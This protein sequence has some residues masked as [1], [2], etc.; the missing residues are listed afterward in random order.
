MCVC[1]FFSYLC[2]FF[3]LFHMCTHIFCCCCFRVRRKA[4]YGSVDRSAF[5]LLAAQLN[6]G[7]GIV[8]AHGIIETLEQKFKLRYSRVEHLHRAFQRPSELYARVQSVLQMPNTLTIKL[9]TMKIPK[10]WPVNGNRLAKTC[11]FDQINMS[12]GQ[13]KS[14]PTNCM[15]LKLDF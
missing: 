11:N 14:M 6:C 7:D 12:H 8:T 9:I 3:I 15:S 13:W 2:A 10:C 4:D 5:R 1:I